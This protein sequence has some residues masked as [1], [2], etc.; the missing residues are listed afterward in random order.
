MMAKS[1]NSGTM[2]VT[3]AMQQSSK[4]IS[5]AIKQYAKPEELLDVMFSVWYVPKLYGEGQQEK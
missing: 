3:N 5:A 4:Y 1:Q 2:E